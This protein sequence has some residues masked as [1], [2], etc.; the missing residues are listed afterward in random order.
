MKNKG[1]VSGLVLLVLGLVAG[2]LLAFVNELT[3]DR[4][5]EEEL[6]L[7]FAAINEFYEVDSFTQEE[8]VL[9]DGGSIYVLRNSETND[10]EHLVYSLSAAGYSGDVEMLVAVN[11]DLSIEG[12]TVTA[13]TETPGVGDKIVGYDFNYT[14]A[15]DLSHFD[16]VSGASAYSSPAVLSIF[17]RVADRVES[18]FGGGLDE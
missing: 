18:D 17:Q 2:L 8:V 11:S 10:I 12:Y 9:E 3:V 6:R 1:L 5:A 7:K 16:T 14:E 4:I 13:Q 15:T